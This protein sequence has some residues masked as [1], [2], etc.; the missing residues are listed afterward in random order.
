MSEP[1]WCPGCH[2]AVLVRPGRDC[3]WCGRRVWR[4]PP[5]GWHR[6]DRQ[7]AS[8]IDP[9]EARLLHEYHARG[10]SLRAIAGTAWRRLGYASPG[11]CLEGIRAAFRREGLPARPQPAATAAANRARAGAFESATVLRVA[12]EAEDPAPVNGDPE[13]APEP[14]PAGRPPPPGR[15]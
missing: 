2:Q 12:A 3:P 4:A 5:G 6:P 9:R 13:P 11:S 8:R 14:E 15:S 1:G 10:L 7:A